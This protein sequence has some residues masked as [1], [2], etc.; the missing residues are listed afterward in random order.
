M[1]FKDLAVTRQSCREFDVNR[2]VDIDTL[3]NIV[4]IANLAPSARN[5]Q[6]YKL[7]VVSGSSSKA[8]SDAKTQSFNDFIDNCSSFIVIAEDSYNLDPEVK[9]MFEGQEHKKFI[10]IGIVTSYIVLAAASLGVDTCILGAMDGEKIRTSLGIDNKVRL[11]IALGYAKEGYDL[12]EKD[13]K[14]LDEVCR[15]IVD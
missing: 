7:Y 12:R 4:E 6:P 1:N 11:V 15:Y 3:K 9:S 2:E 8:I 10:D 5:A 14:D 13:R